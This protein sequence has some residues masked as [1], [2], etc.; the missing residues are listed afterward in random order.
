MYF[1][2][3]ARRHATTLPTSLNLARSR[4]RKLSS[5]RANGARMAH[6]HQPNCDANLSSNAQKPTCFIAAVGRTPA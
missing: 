2:G 3:V 1:I 6:D 5:S 4:E